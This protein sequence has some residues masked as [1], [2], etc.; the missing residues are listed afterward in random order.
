[1]PRKQSSGSAEQAASAAAREVDQALDHIQSREDAEKVLDAVEREHNGETQEDAAHAAA[2]AGEAAAE[3]LTR[4]AQR[5]DSPEQAAEALAAAVQQ[6]TAESGPADEPLSEALRGRMLEATRERLK[7][8]RYL[9][10]AALR[11]MSLLQAWD[12]TAFIAVNHLPRNAYFVKGLRVLATVTNQGM[13]WAAGSLVLAALGGRRGRRASL[14]MLSALALTTGVV[15]RIV[16]VYFRRRRPFVTLVKAMVVGRKPGSWSFPSGHTATSFACASAL[17]RSYR[18]KRPVF[19]G[20]ASVVGFSR[21]YLGHH[22]PIDVLS[23]ATI[24][25]LVSRLVGLAVRR[26]RR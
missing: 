17:G 4:T 14:E 9:Q 22:Y 5:A 2:P 13:A 20:I 15:E 8:H 19:Y 16:K 26:A 6:T 18:R 1:M 3:V 7:P 21:V 25:E 12:A 11:R 23:G 24:G 10:E